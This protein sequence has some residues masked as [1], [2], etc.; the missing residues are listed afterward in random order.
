[1][2]YVF[3]VLL[4]F[5]SLTSNAYNLPNRGIQ[6][7]AISSAGWSNLSEPQKAEILKQVA[8]KAGTSSAGE[9]PTV[10]KVSEWVDIGQKIGQM[11]GGAAKEVGIAVNDFVKTPVGQWTMALIIWKFMGSAIIHLVGGVLVLV[12]GFGFILFM[13]RKSKEVKY[14]YDSEKTDVFGRS[15]L[16]KVVREALS[17]DAVVGFTIS[18]GIVLV[19]VLFTIFTF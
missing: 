17:T 15:R 9:M 16:K 2:K 18:A 7:D 19:V 1:M 13:I 6:S 11:M 10:Q 14:E 5:T 4:F 12:V 8:D 3:A